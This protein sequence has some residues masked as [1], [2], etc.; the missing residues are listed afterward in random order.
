[1]CD[2]LVMPSSRAVSTLANLQADTYIQLPAGPLHCCCAVPQTLEC[3]KLAALSANIATEEPID[4]VLWESYPDSVR[5]AVRTTGGRNGIR[6]GKG[7]G[8]EV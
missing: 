5:T 1:M 8:R 3:M 4:M 7:I 2:Q 6:A